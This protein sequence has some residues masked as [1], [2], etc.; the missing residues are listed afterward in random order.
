MMNV[1]KGM[2]ENCRKSHS[3]ELI[4]KPRFDPRTSQI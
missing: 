2:E 1:P 3:E 4:S